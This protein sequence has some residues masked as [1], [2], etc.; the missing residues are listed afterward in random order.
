MR[1]FVCLIQGQEKPDGVEQSCSSGAQ[2]EWLQSGHSP[3]QNTH[4][5]SEEGIDTPRSL[6]VKGKQQLPGFYSVLL[7]M[8]AVE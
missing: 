2:D 4:S 1:V 5:R 8:D 3:P 7:T 6:A